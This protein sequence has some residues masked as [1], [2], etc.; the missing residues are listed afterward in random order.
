VK[1]ADIEIYRAIERLGN[2]AQA[3][4]SVFDVYDSPSP[5]GTGHGAT[6]DAILRDV[7]CPTRQ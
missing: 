4:R 1:R 3:T 5:A 6:Q 2:I 7:P